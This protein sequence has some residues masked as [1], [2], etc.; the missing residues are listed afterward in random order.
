MGSQVDTL[1]HR[2]V[3]DE[4][5]ALLEA[6]QAALNNLEETR[7][8]LALVLHRQGQAAQPHSDDRGHHGY[9]LTTLYLHRLRLVVKV[10]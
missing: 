4:L 1:R 3:R 9:S 5:D 6:P 2:Y 8:Y 10:R 7:P